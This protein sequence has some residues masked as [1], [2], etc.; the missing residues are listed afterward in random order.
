IIV[1]LVG[2]N[3]RNQTANQVLDGIKEIVE[4]IAKKQT[5]A[6]IL[7]L[8]IPPRGQHP[9][10]KRVLLME[11]NDGLKETLS[12]VPNCYVLDIDPG[13]VKFLAIDQSITNLNIIHAHHH[14]ITDGTINHRDMYDYLHFTSQGYRRAFEI[15]HSTVMSLLYPENTV[16]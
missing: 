16:T 8:K 12:N 13:F 4:L 11:I 3:N 15:V 9:N 2:T 10:P 6:S 5:Q 7:V 1:L 14:G